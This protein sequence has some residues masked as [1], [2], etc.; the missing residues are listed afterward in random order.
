MPHC[1]YKPRFAGG[2]G[3]VS[4]SSELE[5]TTPLLTVALLTALVAG[6]CALAEFVFD[7]G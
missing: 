4:S 5:A 2:A 1:K 3:A 6:R 7:F